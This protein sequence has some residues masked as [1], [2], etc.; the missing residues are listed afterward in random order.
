MFWTSTAAVSY[1]VWDQTTLLK[2]LKPFSPG[3]VDAAVSRDRPE[4]ARSLLILFNMT[5]ERDW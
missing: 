5:C 2:A 1:F 3:M 4:R